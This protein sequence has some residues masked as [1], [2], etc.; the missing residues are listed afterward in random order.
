MEESWFLRGLIIAI[1]F[2]VPAGAI[3]A[4]T[5][6]RTLRNGF[7]AGFVTGL[8]STVADVLYACVGAFGV[9]L[10]SDFLERNRQPIGV[11]CGL[12]IILLGGY[13]LLRKEDAKQSGVPLA[14]SR[15]K[16]FLSSFALAVINPAVI[17]SFFTAFAAFGIT[18]IPN[19][20][21]GIRLI[22]GIGIGT[23]LWWALLVGVAAWLKTKLK[24]QLLVKLGRAMGVLM[25]AFGL[26]SISRVLFI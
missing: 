22:L 5:I 20:E 18:C 23:V 24:P 17:V 6:Q 7:A 16:A 9:T 15:W 25:I 3:G 1:V 26:W 12:M 13:I 2:G 4:L 8:G 21:S 11:I 14:A 10:I 19:L